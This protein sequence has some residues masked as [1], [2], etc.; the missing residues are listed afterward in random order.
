M[1]YTN[2]KLEAE[3]QKIAQEREQHCCA[4]TILPAVLPANLYDPLPE[5]QE[6]VREFEEYQVQTAEFNEGTY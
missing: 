5:V 1:H 6:F 3:L 4:Q 2:Q